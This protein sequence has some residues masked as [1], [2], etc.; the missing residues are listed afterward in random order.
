MPKSIKIFMKDGTERD[1]KHVDRAGGS[2]TKSIKYEGMFAIITDEW[3]D[4]TAIP[5]S[6]IKEIKV[7]ELG[8]RF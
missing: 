5:A 1:F 2:Y 6:D 4:A 7:T 8:G 3:G